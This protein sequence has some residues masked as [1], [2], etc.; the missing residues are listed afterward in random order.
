MVSFLTGLSKYSSGNEQFIWRVVS[1]RVDAI[2]DT[3]LFSP[4]QGL[5]D[6]HISV[7]ILLFVLGLWSLKS[8]HKI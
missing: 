2:C 3:F 7:G 5:W 8:R 6:R 4:T 1:V